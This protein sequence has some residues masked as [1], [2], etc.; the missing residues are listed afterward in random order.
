MPVKRKYSDRANWRRVTDKKYQVKILRDPD[1]QGYVVLYQMKQVR[2]PLFKEYDGKRY[3]V[4]DA[5][6][7][8]L[9][10]FPKGAHYIMTSMYN[11]QGQVV[12]W[13]I[14]ICKVQG[15]TDR[16]VPWFDDL[17]LDVVILPSG[18]LY[19]LDEEEL[20]DAL[21]RGFI[22]QEDYDM[23][24]SEA[25]QLIDLYKAGNFPLLQLSDKHL[26]LFHS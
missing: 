25:N 1:F 5:G 26:C 23:A 21:Q 2:D 12:Q 22:T 14:D 15:V 19:L 7:E 4:A 13:Y 11:N 10:H 20:E 9:Q 16:G 8:W 6:Y 3:C 17:Y 18:Q 24:W